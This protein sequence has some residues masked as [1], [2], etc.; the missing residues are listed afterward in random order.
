MN[1]RNLQRH[2]ASAAAALVMTTFVVGAAIGPAA[3]QGSASAPAQQH[4]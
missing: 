4:A 2:L 3:V 1:I